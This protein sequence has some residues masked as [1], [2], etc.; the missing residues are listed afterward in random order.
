MHLLILGMAVTL[1]SAHA[2]LDSQKS[3]CTSKDLIAHFHL[4]T[5]PMTAYK[6]SESYTFLAFKKQSDM[7][8][9]FDRPVQFITEKLIRRDHRYDKNVEGYALPPVDAAAFFQ[10]AYRYNIPLNSQELRLKKVLL[11]NNNLLFEDNT[12]KIKSALY[13]ASAQSTSGRGTVEHELNHLLFDSTPEHRVRVRQIF[14]QLTP[15]QRRAVLTILGKM[16]YDRK[17]LS[18][19]DNLYGE[20]AA[21]FR[22]PEHLK[23]AYPRETRRVSLAALKIISQPL[24]AL[25]KQFPLFTR[26]P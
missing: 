2:F 20:F 7:A 21:F 22:D 16:G 5:E 19:A 9:M 6:Y 3:F 4:Q 11:D 1:A 17:T 26:C 23:K 8:L 10:Y 25:E 24:L 12:Y 18:V 14:D 15:E 13:L